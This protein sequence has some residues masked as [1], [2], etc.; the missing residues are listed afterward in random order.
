MKTNFRLTK[1]ARYF[2]YTLLGVVLLQ[3]CNE[4]IERQHID[5]AI[6]TDK[7]TNKRYK[8]ELLKGGAFLLKEE[9]IKISGGDT[10]IEYQYLE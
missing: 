4:K 7:I 2:L 5:G 1:T 10:L 3:S 8:I 6:L 9:H